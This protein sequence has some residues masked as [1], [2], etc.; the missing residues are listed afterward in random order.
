MSKSNN[1]WAFYYVKRFLIRNGVQ[2]EKTVNIQEMVF[3]YTM[4]KMNNTSLRGRVFLKINYKLQ[5]D[6]TLQAN[7][8]RINEKVSLVFQ[9]CCL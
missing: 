7:A 6:D 8:K 5:K 3:F 4:T 2:M 1:I 9:I